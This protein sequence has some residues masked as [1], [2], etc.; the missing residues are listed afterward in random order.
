MTSSASANDNV[1]VLPPDVEKVTPETPS[2]SNSNMESGLSVA[3]DTNGDNE[4][5]RQ[6]GDGD[7]GADGEPASSNGQPLEKVESR[8]EKLGKKKT[9]VIMLAISVWTALSP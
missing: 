9:I 3:E 2:Q 8:A 1:V 4:K 7:A 5:D 6:P